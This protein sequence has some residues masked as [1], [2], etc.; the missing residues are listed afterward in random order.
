MDVGT[1]Q[2]LRLFSLEKKR[3]RGD[4]V[5]VFTYVNIWWKEEWNKLFFMMS[6]EDTTRNNG[7]KLWQESFRLN[8]RK[9]FLRIG[10]GKQWTRLPEEKVEEPQLIEGF[11]MAWSNIS[12]GWLMPNWAPR[13]D[14]C[15]FTSFL[16]ALSVEKKRVNYFSKL[17]QVT[18][19]R[20]LWC[21]LLNLV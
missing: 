4:M 18:G 16:A 10:K 21:T 3:L 7:L 14:R 13:W 15:L 2:E 6:T 20:Y 11:W 8:V 1:L 12:Q 5:T 19:W 17:H 9:N